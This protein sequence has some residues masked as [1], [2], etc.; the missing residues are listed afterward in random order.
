M[1]RPTLATAF[2][3]LALLRARWYLR[4]AHQLG[5]R[6]RLWGRPQLTIG[7][8]LTIGN[9]VRLVSTT[10]RLELAV[11]KGARLEIGDGTFVNYGCSIAATGHIRIGNRCSIGTHVTLMDNDFHHV[12][13]E[14]RDALPAPQ[15]ITIGDRVW[16]G[17]RV[18]VL[19][20]VTIGDGSVVGAGSVVTRDIPP[21]CVAAGV[22]ARVI[23]RLNPP[24]VTTAS[25][26]A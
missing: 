7:G 24:P 21:Y 25:T 6:V 10:A 11:S 3:A 23:R 5:R 16:L 13:P 4:A 19:R 12:D 1:N 2:D 9:R 8:I 22:P 14:Q 20:G 17:T 15:P 18:V 26:A